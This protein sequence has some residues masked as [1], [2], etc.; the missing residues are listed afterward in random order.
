VVT[1]WCVLLALLPAAG[2]VGT[3][4][5]IL[6][7]TDAEA[8]AEAD[9]EADA[10]VDSAP[11][12]DGGEDGPADDGDAGPCRPGV[13]G[14]CPAGELC[15]VRGCG[16]GTTGTCVAASACPVDPALVCGCD[17]ATYWNDCERV[18]HGAAWSADGACAGA[19]C[20]PLVAGT[21]PSGQVCAW[22]GCFPPSASTCVVRPSTCA[23][24][25]TPVCGCDGTTYGNPCV[26]LEGGVPID[27]AG[28][29]TAV[30]CTPLCATVT[31]GGLVWRYP[32][33]GATICAVDCTG[34]TAT[35]LLAGW[36]A[37]C[38]SDPTRDAGCVPGMRDLI[39]WGPC[40]I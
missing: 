23:A 5:D 35:C 32:C 38:L 29:C 2:C 4:V 13:A 3:A 40:G 17:G 16:A 8:G 1:R 28:E 34:C 39:A 26:A 30:A 21:C 12:E 18:L 15:D 31:G 6:E 10:E 22:T 19:T 24:T 27:H 11:A 9:A 37:F 36:Y 14:D 25:G 20:V 33:T 7:R